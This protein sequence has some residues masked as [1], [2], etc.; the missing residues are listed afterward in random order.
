MQP[1]EPVKGPQQ[2]DQIRFADTLHFL[3]VSVKNMWFLLAS[4]LATIVA[5]YGR[6]DV[7]RKM[8]LNDPMVLDED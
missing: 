2:V 1:A 8:D 3:R 5:L 6:R 7:V 4:Y